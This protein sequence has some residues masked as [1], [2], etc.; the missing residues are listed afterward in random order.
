MSSE[1]KS[2]VRKGAMGTEPIFSTPWRLR[3]PVRLRF[4][5][6]FRRLIGVFGI[7]M[8]PPRVM[9][10]SLVAVAGFAR[11]CPLRVGEESEYGRAFRAEFVSV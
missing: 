11:G 5:R 9:R 3:D 2:P 10:S 4:Q 7:M 8:G 6:E 1:E